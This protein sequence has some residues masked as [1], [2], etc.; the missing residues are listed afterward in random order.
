MTTLPGFKNEPNLDWSE[1]NGLFHRLKYW[2]RKCESLIHGPLYEVPEE[3][4][5]HFLIH[6]SGDTGADLVEKWTMDGGL[7]EDSKKKLENYW[8]L[9]KQH[10]AFKSNGLIAVV[11]LK[12]LFQESM[13]LDKF[14]TRTR[15]LMEEAEF[16]TNAMK[17]RMVRDTVIAGITDDKI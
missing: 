12:H 5:C 3:Q 2:K 10:V 11:E 7:T 9:F 15:I 8:T 1:A 17:Q 13:T 6:W 16:P 14:H 4:Q